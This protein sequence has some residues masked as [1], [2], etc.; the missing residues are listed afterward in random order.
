M[1]KIA[2][3]V[4]S[5]ALVLGSAATSVGFLAPWWPEAEILNHFRP[6]AVIGSGLLLA[7]SLACGFRSLA[8]G[9]A[10]LFAITLALLLIALLCMAPKDPTARV[11]LRIV[12]LNTWANKAQVDAIVRFIEQTEADIILLQEIDRKDRAAILARLQPIYPQVFFDQRPQRSPAILSKQPWL[13]TG[14]LKATNNRVVAVWARFEQ[15][16]RAFEVASVHT[17][18]PFKPEAQATDIDRLIEFVRNRR[19][20][21]ILGGDFNL[22]PFSWKLTKLAQLTGLKWAQVFSASWPA[23]RFVPV[24]LLDHV[25]L[26]GPLALVKVETGSSVGSDHL[27]VIADLSPQK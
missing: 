1:R 4:L 25:L 9:W 8:T 19:G 27:P 17:G 10:C 26:K 23:N 5:A 21:V 24:V 22:T 18:N 2:R 12:T 13:E 15:G 16:G 20:P 14:V 7:L 11:G 3:T 6:F